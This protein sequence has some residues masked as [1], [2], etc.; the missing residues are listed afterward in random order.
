MPG[1]PATR[2]SPAGQHPRGKTG[3]LRDIPDITEQQVEELRQAFGLFDKDGDGHVTINELQV[4]FESRM[5]QYCS[6]C[7]PMPRLC[8]AGHFP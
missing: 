7:H 8:S 2:N 3:K 1:S 5:L 6:M 4:V